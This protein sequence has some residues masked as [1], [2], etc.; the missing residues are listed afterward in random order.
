MKNKLGEDILTE[1]EIEELKELGKAI[2]GTLVFG[3]PGGDGYPSRTNRFEL[4]KMFKRYL[5]IHDYKIVKDK[6]PYDMLE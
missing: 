2:E 1:E 5:E 3:D 6:P 4:L